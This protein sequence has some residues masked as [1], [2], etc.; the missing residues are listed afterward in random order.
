MKR[1]LATALAVLMLMSLCCTSALAVAGVDDP[2]SNTQ[3]PVEVTMDLDTTHKYFVDIDYP[4]PLVF[5]YNSSVEWDPEEY[6]YVGR[7]TA[8]MPNGWSDPQTIRI[9]N[10]SDLPIRYS[11]A[12]SVTNRNYGDLGI[13]VE[14]GSG[15]IAACA[16]GTVLGS[17][18][19]E[20]TIGITGVPSNS[21]DGM[22]VTLG[23]IDIAIRP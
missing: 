20:F 12:A 17:K 4:Q 16:P 14:G 7:E 2:T 8:D 9:T 13:D 3:V 21:L 11:V 15:S 22:Q 19:A 10:H 18:F 6:S 1:M 5:S 23:A